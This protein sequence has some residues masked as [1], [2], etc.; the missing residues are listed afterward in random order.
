MWTSRGDGGG[1]GGNVTSGGPHM[2]GRVLAVVV[3]GCVDV[4]E[5]RRDYTQMG[6]RKRRVLPSVHAGRQPP[7]HVVVTSACVSF[8]HAQLSLHA[9]PS[10]AT[11]STFRPAVCGHTIARHHR[12]VCSC[13]TRLCPHR[14]QHVKS[15]YCSTQRLVRDGSGIGPRTSNATCQTDR[16]GLRNLVLPRDTSAVLLST[17]ALRTIA[18]SRPSKSITTQGSRPK[19]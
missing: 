8:A 15:N 14:K 5:A 18:H 3:S 4:C 12:V 11:R 6:G 16:D 10:R 2:G 19:D 1:G 9:R 17:E 7:A 13:N